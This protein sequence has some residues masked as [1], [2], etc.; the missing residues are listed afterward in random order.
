MIVLEKT[1]L[2]YSK[3]TIS[4]NLYYSLIKESFNKKDWAKLSNKQ[5]IIKIIFN[6]E[7]NINDA[8]MH[9]KKLIKN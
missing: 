5:L 9:V 6:N 1:Q 3:K 2:N 8:L 7:L 4:Y